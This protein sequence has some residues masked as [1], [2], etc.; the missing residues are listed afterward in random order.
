MSLLSVFYLFSVLKKSR[1]SVFD[2][3]LLS[4]QKPLTACLNLHKLPL[5][6]SLLH[7]TTCNDFQ[8]YC[9][10]EQARFRSKH[11]NGFFFQGFC[12]FCFKVCEKVWE[13]ACKQVFVKL[14][15]KVKLNSNPKCKLKANAKLSFKFLWKCC[16]TLRLVTIKSGIIFY[17]QTYK[18]IWTWISRS[19]RHHCRRLTLR[20]MRR[21]WPYARSL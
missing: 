7:T 21:T 17:N 16:S 18:L 1:K 20:Q 9:L 19:R 6:H 15:V 13:Q 8:M 12:N 11:L 4:S 3:Y 14:S 2:V 5:L 10:F